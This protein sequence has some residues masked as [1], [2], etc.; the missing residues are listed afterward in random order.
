MKRLLYLCCF[1]IIVAL[2]GCSSQNYVEI[3]LIN[4]LNLAPGLYR[5][6]V[7]ERTT[8][9]GKIYQVST[10]PSADAVPD[11]KKIMQYKRT[12]LCTSHMVRVIFNPRP[13]RFTAHGR[14]LLTD[15]MGGH[16]E[17]SVRIA[18]KLGTKVERRDRDTVTIY[19]FEGIPIK[20]VNYPDLIFEFEE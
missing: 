20:N 7:I 5:M 16:T 18:K 17:I 4:R 14:E 15:S 3:P 13:W 11:C 1:S 19:E 2:I 10:Y 12:I 6:R 8:S 9:G